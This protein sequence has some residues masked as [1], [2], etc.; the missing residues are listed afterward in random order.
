M[1][2]C[3]CVC[4]C[5]LAWV[6][7]FVCSCLAFWWSFSSVVLFVPGPPL[8][9]SLSSPCFSV[10][11]LLFA[12]CVSCF[13]SWFPALLAFS[14]VSFS[15]PPCFLCPS[16]ALLL[17]SCVVSPVFACVSFVFILKILRFIFSFSCHCFFPL[18]LPSPLPS[19]ACMLQDMSW[20]RA[21]LGLEL[22]LGWDWSW[23]CLGLGLVL[24]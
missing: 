1:L 12:F 3:V 18:F 17:V 11:Y 14:R 10:G 23:A 9:F 21:C 16:S 22:V 2:W 8:L 6:G 5:V 4:V 24:G 19:L 13:F 7:I 20:A 15:L